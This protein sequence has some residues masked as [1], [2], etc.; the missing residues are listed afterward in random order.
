M[1]DLAS[2][3]K[4]VPRG[5]VPVALPHPQASVR[6]AA[7]S[8]L[9][10]PCPFLEGHE[11]LLTTGLETKG[12]PPKRWR[13]YVDRLTATPVAAL[14][15]GTGLTHATIPAALVRAAEQA[16]LNLFEVPRGAS[17]VSISHHVADVLGA[18]RQREDGE[19]L[20][21]QK[22]LTR[23]AL[24]ADRPEEAL[25]ARLAQIIRGGAA[26][27]RYDGRTAHG[28]A[29]AISTDTYDQVRHDL[30]R[31]RRDGLRG[32]A[33]WQDGARILTIQ[34]LGVK[35]APESYLVVECPAP[36]GRLQRSAITTAS[37]LLSLA[38]ESVRAERRSRRHLRDRALQLC[39]R[40]EHES[41]NLVLD[42]AGEGPLPVKLQA[43][44]ATGAADLVEEAMVW[45]EENEVFCGV[46][47]AGR[48]QMVFD[49]GRI[50]TVKG[51]LS[52]L[53]LSGAAGVPVPA[54]QAE[55]SRETAELALRQRGAVVGLG[56]WDDVA[57][58]GA[59]GL[60]PADAATQYSRAVLADLTPHDI[61]FLDAFL[62]HHGLRGSVAAAL[63][64]HRNTVPGRVRAIEA[65][66]GRSLDDPA[67]RFDLWAALRASG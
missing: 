59:I 5:L 15:F 10:D 39:F 41:A 67:S 28:P 27:V 22:E 16:G 64:I 43:A 51:L 23:A 30:P 25:L 54:D 2:V 11:L 58:H 12:W 62:R 18:E 14:G 3:A 19:V 44:L 45:L 47:Q 57:A 34:P 13:A 53:R 1:T 17:F 48:L 61:E 63:A 20:R 29:G 49:P 42:A 6:W 21:A 55:R 31:L 50:E 52:R 26:I 60:I 4:G 9:E 65:K 32:A 36:G 46:D 33:A 38:A 8:E 35:G 24:H 40:G 66:L 7:V 37:A 56:L